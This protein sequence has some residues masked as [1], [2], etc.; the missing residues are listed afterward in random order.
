MNPP[1]NIDMQKIT[2]R[3]SNSVKFPHSLFLLVI[4]HT[5]SS[6]YSLIVIQLYKIILEST[7]LIGLLEGSALSQGMSSMPWEQGHLMSLESLKA[8]IVPSLCSGE[9]LNGN[10]H[11]HCTVQAYAL[12]IRG[13]TTRD[14]I[15]NHVRL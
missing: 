2:T 9:R 6:P 8:V 7:I 1:M 13:S 3:L 11:P 5:N 14:Q 12:P 4:A 10:T 15:M